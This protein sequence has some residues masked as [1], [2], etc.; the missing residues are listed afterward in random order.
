MHYLKDPNY[1]YDGI[2]LTMG[3]AGFIS[4]TVVAL[5]MSGSG[6]RVKGLG[7]RALRVLT[8]HKPHAL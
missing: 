7:S 5:E 8:N 3:D 2:F 6:S 1:G 4:L